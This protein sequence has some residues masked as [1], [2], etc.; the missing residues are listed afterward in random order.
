MPTYARVKYSN[1]YPGVDLVY[2]GNQSG[3]LEY[4]FV[5]APGADPSAIVLSVA[6][7]VQEEGQNSRIGNQSSAG[8]TTVR[9]APDGDLLVHLRDGDVRLHKPL[10]YQA[11]N[12]A[13]S[14][15][16]NPNAH[17]G[18][19]ATLGGSRTMV[20]SHY[21]LSASN[22]VRFDLGPYDHTR[23]LCID[24]ILYYSTY[25]GGAVSTPATASPLTPMVM[26][27]LRA[28]PRHPVFPTLQTVLMAL[29]KMPLLLN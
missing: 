17:S 28:P 10:V 25:M 19:Q 13:F 4:D 1:V 29:H 14:I 3:Q 16:Q 15:L 23:P 26:P 6:P 2:Y 8:R 27:T 12:S 7:G 24:P 21:V 11:G 5:V 9:I 22:Q 18:L 20:E